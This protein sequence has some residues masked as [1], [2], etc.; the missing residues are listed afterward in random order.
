M[1]NHQSVVPFTFAKDILA[2]P[3]GFAE[4]HPCRDGSRDFAG[5]RGSS[6]AADKL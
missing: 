3:G 4:R 6:D 5:H 2:G 1:T